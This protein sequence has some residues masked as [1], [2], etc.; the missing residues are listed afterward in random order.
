MVMLTSPPSEFAV[1]VPGVFAGGFLTF[2]TANEIHYSELKIAIGDSLCRYS[3]L[4][5]R[6]SEL[7]IHHSESIPSIRYSERANSLWRICNFAIADLLYS[8]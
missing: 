3:E 1:W 5:I 6:C 4:G 8:L 2:A 7:A